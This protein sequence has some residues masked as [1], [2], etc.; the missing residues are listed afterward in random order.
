MKAISL[1]EPWASF[2]IWG[3]KTIETRTHKRF[4]SL[5]AQQILIHAA[6]TFDYSDVFLKHL[7]EYQLSTYKMI[8]K[9]D[10]FKST[11][12]KL[13]GTVYVMGF[14]TLFESDS[15]SA[16]IDCGI[17]KPVRYGIILQTPINLIQPIPYRGYQ[18]PFDVPD[19]III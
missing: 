8:L 16:L 11:A 14:K 15:K 1:Y 5:V 9:T 7:N 18:F 6:K 17:S 19:E 12:G 2:I 3:W 10:Y 4:K 13:I